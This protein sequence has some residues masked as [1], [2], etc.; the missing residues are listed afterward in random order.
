MTDLCGAGLKVLAQHPAALPCFHIASHN[1]HLLSRRFLSARFPPAHVPAVFQACLPLARS[2]RRCRRPERCPPGCPQPCPP[3]RCPRVPEPPGRPRELPRPG[4]TPLTLTPSRQEG[5][6]TQVRSWPGAGLGFCWGS[7]SRLPSSQSGGLRLRDDLGSVGSQ[8]CLS[9]EQGE[10][11]GRCG[12]WGGRTREGRRTHGKVVMQRRKA[13]VNF[14]IN[15]LMKS[16]FSLIPPH[17]GPVVLG[18]SCVCI[19]ARDSKA[20]IL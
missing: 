4:D 11:L 20:Q 12:V 8:C 14:G 5:C 19:S 3:R 13:G 18:R 17:F 9:P 6:T 16:V 2:H 10:L 1:S 15:N 7:S